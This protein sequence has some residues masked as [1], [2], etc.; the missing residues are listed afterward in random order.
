[1]IASRFRNLQNLREMFR[2][3]LLPPVCVCLAVLAAT[4]CFPQA[5]PGGAPASSVAGYPAGETLSYGI[6]WRLIYAG[7]ARMSFARHKSAEWESKLHL[8]S[9]G[10]VS[11]LY[12]LEDNYRVELL[13]QFCATSS[14]FD[15]ME[16]TRRRQTNVTFDRSSNK[17]TYLEKDLV[18]NQVIQTAETEIPACVSDIIGGLYKLRTM[19]LEPGQSAQLAISD[20]KKAVSAKVEAIGKEEVSTKA[21]KFQT[22]RYEAFVFNGVLYKKNAKLEIWMTEDNRRVPVQFRARMPFPIGTITFQLEKDERS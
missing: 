13:D 4:Q 6:E 3:S 5:R 18:K 7:S 15:A 10:L 16:G 20:G 8:E 11:R 21:G 17:A 1:M 22:M 9:A 14:E 2:N 12:K 19:H